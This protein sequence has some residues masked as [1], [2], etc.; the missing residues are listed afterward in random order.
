[1]LFT[2]LPIELVN[3]APS[4]SRIRPVLA[5]A[6][7]G[8]ALLGGYAGSRI[9]DATGS[10]QPATGA[11]SAAPLSSRVLAPSATFVASGR[12]VV[13]HGA[14]DW[15]AFEPSPSRREEIRRLGSLGFVAGATE[16][17]RATGAAGAMVTS[18]V[19]QFA[20]ATGAAQELADRYSQ[21]D[22][23]PGAKFS[24][25]SMG[26]PGAR[27]VS[28]IAG[29]HTSATVMFTQG[30]F[31]YAVSATVPPGSKNGQVWRRLSSATGLLYESANG[32]AA[33][34]SSRSSRS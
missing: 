26:L 18:T 5:A 24:S 22:A 14:A 13:L 12:P 3:S 33:P 21:R 7:A 23:Q 32:C 34:S 4:P 15:A 16:R 8:V 29:G 28:V 20:G 10:G 27:A 31:F 1:M 30:S 25:L 6:L 2:G 11:M 17:L 9:V 19:E